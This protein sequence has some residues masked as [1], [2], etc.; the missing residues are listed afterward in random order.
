MPTRFELREK[1]ALDFQQALISAGMQAAYGLLNK[2]RFW[3]GQ[4]DNVDEDIF[5]VYDVTD[6]VDLESADNK[7]FRT[8]QYING[9]LF[10]RSGFDDGDFQDLAIAIEEEC[11]KA[12][13]D[14]KWTNESRNNAID[15]ESPIY[16]I[17]FEAQK[18]YRK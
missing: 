10:T 13:I 11:E 17:N 3:R 8:E 16:F 6:P 1:F 2:P 4:V 12:E 15:T 18:V 5:L 9:Q 14:I 7:L